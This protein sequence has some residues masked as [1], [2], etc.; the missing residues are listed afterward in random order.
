MKPS[1]LESEVLGFLMDDLEAPQSLERNVSEALARPIVQS[2]IL[3]ALLRLAEMGLAQ[4]FEFER[5]SASFRPVEV[6][7]ALSRT[8]LWFK[9]TQAGEALIRDVV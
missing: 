3:E 9:A 2:E 8:D 1:H 4:A 5:V 7:N 6:N